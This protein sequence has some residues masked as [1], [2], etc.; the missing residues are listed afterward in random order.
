[1]TTSF[2]G[3][4]SSISLQIAPIYSPGILGTQTEFICQLFYF[5]T[6]KIDGI[7]FNANA[8]VS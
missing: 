5:D 1:M 8:L 4:V 2:E 3:S 6:P 7:A